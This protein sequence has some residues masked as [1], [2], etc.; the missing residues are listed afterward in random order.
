VRAPSLQT[1]YWTPT[2]LYG[3]AW[4]VLTQ[5]RAYLAAW[6]VIDLYRALGG[7]WQGASGLHSTQCAGVRL[8]PLPGFT[9]SIK[10]PTP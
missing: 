3:Q 10:C 2:Y 8:K 5:Q 4:T 7:G 6:P 9:A 1:T